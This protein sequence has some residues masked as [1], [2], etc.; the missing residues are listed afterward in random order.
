MTKVGVGSKVD[1]G[2][3]ANL[4]NVAVQLLTFQASVVN[5]EYNEMWRPNHGKR[6]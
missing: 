6:R 1:W 5:G 2:G 3:E 4:D